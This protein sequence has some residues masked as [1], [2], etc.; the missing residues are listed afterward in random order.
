MIIHIMKI[1][2]LFLLP[3]LLILLMPATGL[4]QSAGHQQ[5]IE[6]I[7]EGLTD[8]YAGELE[9]AAMYDDLM[10]YLLNP[11]NINTADESDLAGLYFVDEL[12]ISNIIQYRE[13]YGK[14][15]SVYELLY[16][17]G[18]SSDD[19]RKLTPFITAEIITEATV[20]SP[21]SLIRHGRHQAFLRTQQVI[22]KQ[23]GFLP[24]SDSALARNPNSRYLGSPLKIYHRYQV[25]YGRNYQAGF[26][27]EKDPGEEFFKG[28]NPRGFDY[29]TVHFQMNDAGKF[30][31]IV[32]G[33]FQAGFGQGLVL[34]SGLDFS[35]SANTLNIRKNARGIQKYSSTDEN[36]FFRG[37]GATYR[38]SES[39]GGTLFVSRKKIDAGV[40]HMADNGKINEVSSLQT[41]GL[42][43]TPSQMSGKKVLGETILGGNLDYNH[44]LF[45]VGATVA[46]L[47]YDAVLNLPERVY[48][49]FDFNGKNNLNGGVDYHFAA[50]PVRFFGEGAVCSSGGTAYVT[51][52]MANV[53]SRMSISSLYRYY[54]RDYHA[55]FS[56]GFRENSR[57]ANERGFYFGTLIHPATRWKLSA[58]IDLFHFPWMRYGAYA[59]SSGIE[60][61]FQ[62]DYS[63][64]RNLHMY[65]S[66]KHKEK[67]L[68]SSA[69]D[70]HSRILSDAATS[71]MRYNVNYFVTSEIELRSRMEVSQYI[72]E[73]E[74]PER[75]FLMYQDVLF[76]PRS[77]P[78]SLAFRFA[79]FKTGSYNTRFYAYENDVLY[80]FS[81]PAYYDNGYRTYLL[82]QYNAGKALDIW[83]RY[84]ITRLPGRETI[85]TGLNEIAG[86]ARS[87]LK[88]QVRV[89][90]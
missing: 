39:M 25:N 60:Y 61:F 71:R 8:P 32:L 37:A 49:Q 43:A 74:N 72:R 11:L 68:N 17:D 57:T 45:R 64:S 62:T 67:P 26:V 13:R 84:S 21:L 2:H 81:M 28:S 30:S 3:A 48:N 31:T 4:A 80:A 76:K 55:Y 27:A 46:A 59:P 88:A 82:M 83:V 89:K 41:T 53:N 9:I 90:F 35:K 33:D 69:A 14:F 16:V 6:E 87:E 73:F 66:F 38:L 47:N 40:S 79:A 12:Q 18:F 24:I 77:Y 15:M 19:L 51:G 29:L 56:N 23:R 34:W 20:H 70:S 50:G 36:M 52:V 5:L 58:Y 54:T 85:G 42:H 65:L 44:R 63:Y 78:F 86:D 10:F 1:K 22:Q 75:G 7:I